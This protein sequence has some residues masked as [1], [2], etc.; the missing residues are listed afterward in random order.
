MFNQYCSKKNYKLLR[1]IWVPSLKWRHLAKYNADHIQ[2][3]LDDRKKGTGVRWSSVFSKVPYYCNSE[4]YRIY[5]S[6]YDHRRCKYSGF[7]QY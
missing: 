6:Q 2:V 1:N 3:V 5:A 4:G 7:H